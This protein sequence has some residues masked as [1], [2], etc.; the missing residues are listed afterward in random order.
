M[1]LTNPT[2]RYNGGDVVCVGLVIIGQVVDWSPGSLEPNPQIWVPEEIFDNIID[3]ADQNHIKLLR[4]INL[5]HQTRISQSDCRAMLSKWKSMIA[6]LD[7]EETR[8]FA[9]AIYELVQICANS[10]DNLELLIEGP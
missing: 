2:N 4:K 7:S 5:F 9:E 3:I 6:I 1:T 10:G 8:I